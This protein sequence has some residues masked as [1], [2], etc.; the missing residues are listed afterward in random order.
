MRVPSTRTLSTINPIAG[1][2]SV[3]NVVRAPGNL[4]GAP[5]LIDAKG[6]AH[7]MARTKPFPN[8]TLGN[9]TIS[10]DVNGH[11]VHVPGKG[12]IAGRYPY[13]VGMRN[14]TV[15]DIAITAAFFAAAPG[16]PLFAGDPGVATQWL[17]W[18]DYGLGRLAQTGVAS[19]FKRWYGSEGDGGN[20]TPRH[21]GDPRRPQTYILS[22]RAAMPQPLAQP[23]GGRTVVGDR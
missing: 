18:A 5:A 9:R 3:G 21:T 19:G 8:A 6:L 15:S 17:P 4:R 20:Q 10:V 11:T 12:T 14:T 23:S 2:G 16:N 22:G 1:V 13:E 7:W